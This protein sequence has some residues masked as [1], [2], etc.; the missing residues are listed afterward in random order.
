MTEFHEEMEVTERIRREDM[1]TIQMLMD[2]DDY[3]KANHAV[4][5]KLLE[6]YVENGAA[7]LEPKALPHL[8]PLFWQPTEEVVSLLNEEALEAFLHLRAL[9]STLAFLSKKERKKQIKMFL[10]F[11]KEYN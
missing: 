2:Q 7:E 11:V 6:Q 9:I 8:K 1:D 4:T 10:D 5:L 3:S